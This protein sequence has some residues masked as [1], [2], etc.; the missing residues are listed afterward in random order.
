MFF[1]A[2][3][4]SSSG[5]AGFFQENLKKVEAGWRRALS[6]KARCPYHCTYWTYTSSASFFYLQRADP[7]P[8]KREMFSKIH[9]Y[10]ADFGYRQHVEVKEMTEYLAFYAFC[11]I[12]IL[13][14]GMSV[15]SFFHLAFYVPYYVY[16]LR[17][18]GPPRPSVRKSQVMP[19]P[20]KE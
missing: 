3:V 1:L 8:A 19:L 13:Y 11:N 2:N 4:R 18:Y 12:F 15:I 10:Y 16:V 17:K 20:L 14:L 6:D 9:V 5:I 7:A